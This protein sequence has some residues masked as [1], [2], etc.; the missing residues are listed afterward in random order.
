MNRVSGLSANA[1][2]AF[3]SLPGEPVERMTHGL[4]MRTAQSWRVVGSV[5]TSPVAS[6]PSHSH[7]KTAVKLGVS[8]IPAFDLFK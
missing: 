6:S 3:G 2:S 1:L 8:A 7:L 4:P 5:P